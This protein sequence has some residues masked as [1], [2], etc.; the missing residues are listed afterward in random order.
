MPCVVPAY[1]NC[2]YCCCWNHCAAGMI[3]TVNTV[4]P[5]HPPHPPPH[6]PHLPLSPRPPPLPPR[7]P[8]P[9]PPPPR[10]CPLL[11]TLPG[12]TLAYFQATE[13]GCYTNT[14]A[15]MCGLRLEQQVEVQEGSVPASTF[16]VYSACGAT[17]PGKYEFYV[18]TL[19]CVDQEN[20]F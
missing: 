14:G 17:P 16:A 11:P 9:P 12:I 8:S 3:L 5:P 20:M 1:A 19:H 13:V 6:P 2:S 4:S 7:P 10:T 15:D 18:H